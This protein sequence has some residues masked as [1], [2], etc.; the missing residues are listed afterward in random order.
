MLR[1]GLRLVHRISPTFG[2]VLHETWYTLS[3][4]RFHDVKRHIDHRFASTLISQIAFTH[5]IA[6]LRDDLARG[7]RIAYV[8]NF[9]PETTGI[10]SCTFHS[11]LG[12]EDKID[13]FC[14]VGDADW[15]FANDLQ[16]RR[17]GSDG[18]RLLDVQAFL[19]ADRMHAYEVIV[20][21]VGNSDHCAYITTALRK[22]EALEGNLDRVVF[23]VHDPFVLNLIEKGSGLSPG[24]LVVALTK[25]G[26]RRAVSVAAEAGD[27][28]ASL[29]GA[30][31][32]GMR[33]FANLGVRRFLV[34]SE[35]ARQILDADLAGLPVEIGT[36]FHPV[37]LPIG[38]RPASGPPACLPGDKLTIGSFGHAG[39]DKLTERVISAVRMLQDGGTPVRLLL[40]GFGTSRYATQQAEALAD[41]DVEVLDGPSDRLLCRAMQAADVAV[42]LRAENRGE[43]SGSVAQLIALGRRTIVADVGAFRE[44]GPAVRLVPASPSVREVVDAILAAMH[45]PP[46]L[47]AMRDYAAARSPDCFRAALLAALK[48]GPRTAQHLP[49]IPI[50]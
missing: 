16:M 28:H 31:I 30:G 47:A 3:G 12:S 17:G 36:L 34:N 26:Q 44:Y 15:F 32:S 2:R 18:P 42:Q 39:G 13:I 11:F 22:A 20:F 41:L 38:V 14:P 4:W 50:D 23:H 5:S 49:L 9:P 40:A 43:S 45:E 25:G 21:A 19:T 10:A 8:S 1:G 29:A 7:P 33:F 37:F 35:A 46:P 27:V 24:E 48:I 6:T